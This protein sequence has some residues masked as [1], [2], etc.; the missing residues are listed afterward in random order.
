MSIE[1]I[2]AFK[3]FLVKSCNKIDLKVTKRK[4]KISF[5]DVIFSAMLMNGLNLSY[6]IVNAHMKK[7]KYN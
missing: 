5:K 3:N 2:S 7:K 4:R 1:T 6:E